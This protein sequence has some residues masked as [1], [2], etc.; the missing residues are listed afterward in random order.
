MDLVDA[1]SKARSQASAREWGCISWGVNFPRRAPARGSAA[2]PAEARAA[3][4]APIIRELQATGITSLRAIAAGLNQRGV[5][6]G[7][8]A[9][10]PNCWPACRPRSRT[11][12]GARSL[13][14]AA[15]NSA[16]SLTEITTIH[17]TAHAPRVSIGDGLRHINNRAAPGTFRSSP[18]SGNASS[19]RD[20]SSGPKPA[21]AGLSEAR[22]LE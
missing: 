19:V 22:R 4:L 2:A 16:P 11:A 20:F 10:A 7:K 15:T 18:E 12:L 5:G 6:S 3:D 21:I 13:V 1:S 14:D 8:P 9:P 17:S